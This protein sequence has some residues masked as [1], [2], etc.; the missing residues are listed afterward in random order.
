MI[1]K[2]VYFTNLYIER[3]REEINYA[4]S[5][6]AK[7]TSRQEVCAVIGLLFL[8]GLKGFQH[9]AVQEIW[10]SDGT[11]LMAI[12]G[13]M[14]YKRFLFLLRS[15]RFDDKHSRPE[16]EM[17]DKLAAIR[18]LYDAFVQNCKNCYTHSEFITVDEKLVRF[19]GNFSSIQYIPS[20]PAKYGIKI[21]AVTDAKT[22]YTSSIE[23][24]CG[25]Q[26]PGPYQISNKP[27]DIVHRL[28]DHIKGDNRNLTTDN[29]Y[30][31][32][33]LVLSML[34]CKITCI[35]TLRKNKKEIPPHFLPEKSRQVGSTLFGFQDTIMLVS[36]VPKTNK[37]VLLL[38]SMHD[39]GDIDPET[40]K[41]CV[42]LDYN[43]TKGG[44]DTADQ[45]EAK[46][47]VS[48][49]TRRWTMCLF[50]TFLNIA[51]INAHV[52]HKHNTKTWCTKRREFLKHLPF[53]LMEA[54]YTDRA[55][56]ISLPREIRLF[57]EKYKKQEEEVELER[58]TSLSKRKRCTLCERK[59]I[60]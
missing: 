52:I 47:S 7:I 23:I 55:M 60:E 27:V 21:F 32:Y 24:Y 2:I 45:M 17:H 37:A 6:D 51:G 58:E 49:I 26:K 29:W 57:L 43:M 28:T 13:C 53:Q 38:S 35:G 18:T 48:R 9:T 12:R 1:D 39:S 36:H 11:G 19:R 31:T 46:Y 44:V 50:F 8:M 34:D 40:G 20:K 22:F 4:R 30:T 15:I 54:L 59:K 16:R 25:I 41:P 33:D 10:T 42:I 3:R 14:G 56:I 5:R